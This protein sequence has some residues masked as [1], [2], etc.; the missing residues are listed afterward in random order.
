MYTLEQINEALGK[1][2]NGSSMVA[3]LQGLISKTNNEAAKHRVERNKVLDAL[4][5]RDGE[6]GGLDNSLANLTGTLEALKKFGEPQQMGA[7]LT[8]LQQQV[9]ELSD[10]YAASEKKA[11]EEHAKRVRSNINAELTSALAAGKAVDA[12]TF[13]KLLAD[14]VTVK[15]DGSFIFK[16]GDKEISIAD[17]VKDW[18]AKNTWAVK[19]DSTGGAGSKPGG[20][21]G[22]Y[23]M[24][25]LKTMSREEIN[26]HWDEISKGVAK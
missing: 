16:D 2:E 1:F 21:A 18:L 9:K 17:G 20:E 6:G 3:D 25:N 10:K 22:K 12:K 19:N 15:D 24:E 14:N 23:T 8:A 13:T 4:G 26:A 11:A 5:L 7:Q